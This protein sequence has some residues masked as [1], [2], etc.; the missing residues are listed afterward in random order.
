MKPSRKSHPGLSALMGWLGKTIHLCLSLILVA[1]TLALKTQPPLALSSAPPAA[2]GHLTPQPT[3]FSLAE[4]TSVLLYLPLATKM[5]SMEYKWQLWRNGPK[6]RGANIWQRIRVPSDENY[7]GDEYIGPPYTLEDFTRLAKLGANYVNLS[8]P[9]LFTEKPP[10]G[11]DE[12][13]VAHLDQLLELVA[14]ADLFAV[15]S[16]RTGPGRSDFTFYRDGAGVWYPADLL[17]ETV[18]TDQA[19]QNAWADMWQYAAERYRNHPN[20]VGYTL[21]VEPNADEV[22]LDLYDPAEFYPTYANTLYDWNRFYPPLVQA[23]RQVDPN[24]PILLSGMGWASVLWLPYLQPIADPHLV[25][26]VDQ[27]AP[28]VYTHQSPQENYG[29]PG[30]FDLNWDNQPDQFDWNWMASYLERLPTYQQTHPGPQAVNEFGVARWAPQADD[31]LTDQINY[32]ET[33]QMNYAVWVWD[34]SY[35]PWQTW[36]S[37]AMNYLFGPD[38]NNFSEVPNDLFDVLHNAWSSNTLRPSNYP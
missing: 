8:I 25:F 12:N 16:F 22:A 38:P 6:L 34:S 9:G 24:T 2:E 11:V 7:L 35:G 37:K 30:Q 15:I 17:I 36:G 27:Y 28:F 31:F 4:N 23:I 14:Q 19:A 29:Y 3:S 18:W 33:Q 13:A 32:F 20:V 1:C 10:Y 5:N 26:V 21:M